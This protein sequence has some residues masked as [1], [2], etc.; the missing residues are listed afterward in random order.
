[1]KK[2]K[3]QIIKDKKYTT[4]KNIKFFDLIKTLESGQTFRYKKDNYLSSSSS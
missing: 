1:M 2:V 4:I 3:L